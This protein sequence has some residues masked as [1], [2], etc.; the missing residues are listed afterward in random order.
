MLISDDSQ[1]L[2]FLINFLQVIEEVRRILKIE[3]VE[4]DSFME[5]CLTRLRN[6]VDHIIYFGMAN[7]GLKPPKGS[8][9]GMYVIYNGLNNFEV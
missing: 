7:K 4:R 8:H 3:A 5:K 6:H 9:W 1:I 2:I